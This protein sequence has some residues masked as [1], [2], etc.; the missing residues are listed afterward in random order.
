MAGEG[1]RKTEAAGECRIAIRR[2]WQPAESPRRTMMMP[3]PGL[4]AYRGAAK[5]GPRNHSDGRVRRS[6]GGATVSSQGR[7]PLGSKNDHTMIFA[8]PEGRP[9]ITGSRH[10]RSPLRGYIR[11][12]Y[13]IMPRGLHPWLLTVAPPGLRKSGASSLLRVHYYSDPQSRDLRLRCLCA[14]LLTQLQYPQAF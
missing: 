10:G 12:S 13:R 5:S 2:P 4:T 6:P 3:R 7:K 1:G 14:S 9:S 8:A 11:L